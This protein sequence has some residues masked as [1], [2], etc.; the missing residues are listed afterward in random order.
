MI[1][2]FKE[3]CSFSLTPNFVLTKLLFCNYNSSQEYKATLMI[4]EGF[5]YLDLENQSSNLH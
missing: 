5:L 2:N 3:T 4:H 1:L